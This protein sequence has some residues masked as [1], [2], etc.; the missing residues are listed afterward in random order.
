M[1]R[2]FQGGKTKTPKKHD[3]YWSFWVFPAK[4]TAPFPFFKFKPPK[5]KGP[6]GF[7]PPTEKKNS[8]LDFLGSVLFKKTPVIGQLLKTHANTRVAFFGTEKK[9]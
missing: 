6:P 4:I 3:I 2:I 9:S 5:P 7:F 1:G 8:F